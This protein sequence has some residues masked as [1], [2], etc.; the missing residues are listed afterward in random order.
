LND[1]HRKNAEWGPHASR[2]DAIDHCKLASSPLAQAGA[3]PLIKTNFSREYV[4]IYICLLTLS[5][6]SNKRTLSL[7]GCAR[8]RLG[9]QESRTC[10]RS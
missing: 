6:A 5:P 8:R 10:L 1:G 4:I 9:S 7:I 3:Q 2:V